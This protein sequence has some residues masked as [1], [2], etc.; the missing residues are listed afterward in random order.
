[1][2]KKKP[3]I[4][5]LFVCMGNICRSPTAEGVFRKLIETAGR[6]AE[7]EV[8]SAG[9][10]GYHQGQRADPRMR[11]A[12]E[13]RGYAL[14]SLARRIEQDDF[15]RFDLIVTMDEDN[16]RDVDQMNPE[17]RARVV[18]MCDYCEEHE[19]SEV[20]DPYYGGERGFHTVIDILEDSCGNLLRRI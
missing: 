19:V 4:A 13:T 9:T 10:I 12:A 15:D 7:F 14:D 16:Y 11:A 2:T 3:A 8:D 20:P 1:M 6:E 5:V 17:S 18:R